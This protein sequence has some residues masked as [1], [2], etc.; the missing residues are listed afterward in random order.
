MLLLFITNKLF[1]TKCIKCHDKK[2]ELLKT[3][4]W[5][6]KMKIYLTRIVNLI[7][8]KGSKINMNLQY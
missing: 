5:N 8:K 3:I 2:S 6:V 7:L 4:F 1:L